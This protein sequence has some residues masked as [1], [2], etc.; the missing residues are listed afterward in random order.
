MLKE[1][2]Q[3]NENKNKSAINI[4]TSKDGKTALKVKLEKETVWLSQEQIAKLFSVDRS[5]ITRHI[6]NVFKDGE[7]DEKS[8]VQKIH[9]AHSD[10]PTKFYNLDII[11][12]IGYRVNAS[13]GIHFRRW[14]SE[15]LKNYLVKGFSV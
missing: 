11:L 12:S 10:R 9:F 1:L 15:T 7:V 2:K 3:N 13:S 14:V 4:Y 5:V 8:N 6:K